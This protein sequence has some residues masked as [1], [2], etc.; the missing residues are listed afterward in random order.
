MMNKKILIGILIGICGVIILCFIFNL[1]NK[2]TD[3]E[4]LKFLREI[5]KEKLP[6]PKFVSEKEGYY[7]EIN[8][9]KFL[10]IVYSF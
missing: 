2:K 8:L 1:I 7:L 4:T 6:E 9:D 5:I 3:N 10:E